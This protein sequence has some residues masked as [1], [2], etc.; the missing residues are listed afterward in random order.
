M[1]HLYLLI[2]LLI[3]TLAPALS[4]FQQFIDYFNSL[5]DPVAKQAAS[6]KFRS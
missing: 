1:K 4:Q 3:S 6:D 5:G 2:V